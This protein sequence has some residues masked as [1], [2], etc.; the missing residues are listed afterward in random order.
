MA[1]YR[2]C[3]ECGA[4]LDPGERCECQ[5][6]TKKRPP[7]RT[8]TASEKNIQAQFI[9]RDKIRQGRKNNE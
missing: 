1:Y 9:S 2:V 8:G 7:R 3:S 6:K 4:N 5:M